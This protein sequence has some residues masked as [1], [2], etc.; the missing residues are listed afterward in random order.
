M[1]CQNDI[2]LS[3]LTSEN[4]FSISLVKSCPYRTSFLSFN[5]LFWLYLTWKY[6]WL[7]FLRVVLFV[8]CIYN[9]WNQP[10]IYGCLGKTLLGCLLLSMFSS[11]ILFKITQ[12]FIYGF[13]NI[14]LS[15]SC[16][17]NV[18]LLRDNQREKVIENSHAMLLC[19]IAEYFKSQILLVPDTLL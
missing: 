8:H 12:N 5:C 9:F 7:D 2:C 16:E 19:F 14:N 11:K 17:L 3:V 13:K 15:A 1:S 6:L 4:D 10:T 18:C